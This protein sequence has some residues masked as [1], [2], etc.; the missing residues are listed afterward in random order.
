ML[1]RRIISVRHITPNTAHYKIEMNCFYTLIRYIMQA[2][3]LARAAGMHVPVPR[4]VL[5]FRVFAIF[6]PFVAVEAVRGP[7]KHFDLESKLACQATFFQ[8]LRRRFLAFDF[9]KFVRRWKPNVGRIFFV[10]KRRGCR[11]MHRCRLVL[12]LRTR[13]IE[14]VQPLFFQV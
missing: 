13:N 1:K 4:F 3:T 14:R 12:V 6:G 10:G 5:S 2:A 8:L 9:D 11:Q 7:T